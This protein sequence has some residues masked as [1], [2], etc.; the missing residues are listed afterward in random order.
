ME[1]NNPKPSTPA[2][3]SSNDTPLSD[4][5]PPKYVPQF[6]AATE[7]ILKRINSG[8]GP[9]APGYEDVKRN[10]LMGMKTSMNMEIPTLPQTTGRR[11]QRDPRSVGSATSTALP[12]K[13]GTPGSGA[14]KSGTPSSAGQRKKTPAKTG[15]KRKRHQEESDEDTG[16]ESEVMSKLG[17]DSESDGSGSITDFPKVT[18]SGRAV[19]K[20]TQF[21]PEIKESHRPK[22][23]P[24]KKAQE[25]ALCKRC[26][27]GHSPESNMIVFCD[28]C[29]GGWHQ[30]CHDPVVSD[31][32][33][34]DENASWFCADCTQKRARKSTSSE[35]SQRGVSW[36]GR[37]M[38]DVSRTL[39]SPPLRIQVLNTY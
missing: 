15:R 12:H 29:N 9:H 4:S 34:K 7:M 11:A 14:Q 5:S 16:S 13:A 6:S 2:P 37:S 26:G 30:M 17:G 25:Q 18:Q 19:V 20:P 24:S 33:V 21:V 38:D 32:V 8:S 10:L 3:Q 31:E 28:G 1:Y 36:Q 22:R 35:Q 39:P 23:G 27:R